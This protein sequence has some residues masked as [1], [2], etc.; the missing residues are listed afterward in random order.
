MT[1]QF[2]QIALTLIAPSLS[3]PRKTFNQAKLAELAESIKASGVHQP[4]LVRML[5]GSRA[6]DTDRQVIYELVCGERRLRASLMAGV[7]TIPTMIRDLSD[8]QVLEIQIVEN[9]QRDD[10]SP[11]EEAEGYEQ[12][13]RHSNLSAEQVAQKI[14]KSR[15]YVF[16]RLKL[17]DL[18]T[19]GRA[20]LRDGKIEASVAMLVARIPDGKQQAKFLKDVLRGD[21]YYGELDPLSYRAAQQLAQDSYMLKL[22]D[23]R[24]KSTAADLLPG[25]GSCKDCAKRTGAN[26]D[27]FADVKSADVCTDPSCYH[28]KEEAATELL[29]KEAEAKGQTVIAGD[30]AREL[31]TNHYT[32]AYKGYKRLDNKE[33]S[34]T[35][36]PLRKIIGKLMEERGIKP[37]M[38]ENPKKKGQL[39]ACL[40]NDVANSLLKTVQEQAKANQKSA[41][42]EIKDLLD[43]KASQDKARLDAKFEREVRAQ[44]IAETWAEIL[45]TDHMDDA[46][47]IGTS[48]FNLDVH[49]MLA[50]QA[51]WSLDADGAAAAS[52]LLA[53][54]SVGA[55]HGLKELAK[56]HPR[57]DQLHLL[58]LLHA[59]SGE[60]FGLVTK[61]VWGD[62]LKAA[63][64]RIEAEVKAR[65]YPKSTA[66]KAPTT[67]APAAQARGARGKTSAATIS[68]AEAKQGIATAMQGLEGPASAPKG[69]VAPTTGPA[70]GKQAAAWPFQPTAKRD[71]GTPAA[72]RQAT[73][74][75]AAQADPIDPLYTKALQTITK[76][77]KASVRLLKEKL[78]IGTDRA[79]D[80]MEQLEA[81][82]KVSAA[83]E[84]GARKVLVAA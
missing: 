72:Q 60:G 16:N 39:E 79:M 56:T 46:E 31:I 35:D 40:P 69:A 63:T 12:L 33:D 25:V 65:I 7:D 17:L 11:L 70:G 61:A 22:S 51:A 29:V 57:P 68:A 59:R 52:K 54:G 64:T 83:E 4:V 9:L 43:E 15:T 75:D 47:R 42:K 77:Q 73:A 62:K 81:A 82:G 50:S 44:I 6:P 27:L 74:A 58:F 13:M 21:G 2:A 53:T 71:R 30:E 26:P 80:L 5:P 45:A 28:K 78:S 32:G 1:N 3:N 23:A 66:K 38:L 34:P 48:Y 18:G 10:L 8:A 67:P 41:P 19:D 37:T 14:G 55:Q 24:F 36:E 76:A 49:R 84:R 20:A